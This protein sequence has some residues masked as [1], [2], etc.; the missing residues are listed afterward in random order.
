MHEVCVIIYYLPPPVF[1]VPVVLDGDV[2]IRDSNAAL[3]Y[4]SRTRNDV[5]ADHWYPKDPIGQAK[6]DEYLHWA[7][8]NSRASLAMYAQVRKH[9]SSR[10][11]YQKETCDANFSQGSGYKSQPSYFLR[12][13]NNP[14][15]FCSVPLADTNGEERASQ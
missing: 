13:K 11:G 14:S 10:S 8:F 3:L 5:V 1:Q 12:A 9:I 7:H 2:P 4:I 15:P 6:V